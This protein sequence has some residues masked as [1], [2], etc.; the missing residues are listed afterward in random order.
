M[1]EEEKKINE[2]RAYYFYRENIPVHIRD[3]KN[4]QYNGFIVE[5]SADFFILNDRLIGEMPIFF[6]EIKKIE[7]FKEKKEEN[8]KNE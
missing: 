2:K 1:N 3:K 7:R 5:F 8:E 6:Q 4:Y